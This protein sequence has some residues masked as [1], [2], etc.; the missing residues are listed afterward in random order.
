MNAKKQESGNIEEAFNNIILSNFGNR[1]GL[2]N[3]KSPVNKNPLR[4]T[5]YNSFNRSPQ[6]SQYIQDEYSQNNPKI[7]YITKYDTED[8]NLEENININ[9]YL[10]KNKKRI[11][12]RSPINYN[13]NQIQQ[14]NNYY[15]YNR[16]NNNINKNRV[17]KHFE[18]DDF[19]NNNMNYQYSEDN[20]NDNWKKKI[21]KI[22]EQKSNHEY[23]DKINLS[24][25]NNK[26]INY[27]N[28][29]YYQNDYDNH[30][31]SQSVTIN[32]PQ[33]KNFPNYSGKNNYNNFNKNY[34]NL[35]ND[36]YK[37]KASEDYNISYMDLSDNSFKNQT[38]Q[39]K[40]YYTNYNNFPNFNLNNDSST[41]NFYD[42][43]YELNK[44]EN[45]K[46]KLKNKFSDLSKFFSISSQENT[47]FEY[48]KDDDSYNTVA[49]RRPMKNDEEHY[50]QNLT[51]KIKKKDDKKKKREKAKASAR[52]P[53][54]PKYLDTTPEGCNISSL[55]DI[56]NIKEKKISNFKANP[57]EKKTNKNLSINS[58]LNYSNYSENYNNLSSTTMFIPPKKIKNFFSF[59]NPNIKNDY[60]A[61]V[62]NKQIKN[63]LN[64]NNNNIYFPEKDIS[65]QSKQLK[66]RSPQ[67]YNSFNNINSSKFPLKNRLNNNQKNIENI[68]I[69]TQDDLYNKKKKVNFDNK[70]KEITVDLS[71]RKKIFDLSSSNGN[72]NNKINNITPN[73][74]NDINPNYNEKFNFN[75]N[76]KPKPKTKIESCIITFDKPKRNVNNSYDKQ[77]KLSNSFDNLKF[78]QVKYV[79][80]KI[81]LNNN[82]NNLNNNNLYEKQG[83]NNIN[84]TNKNKNN[85]IYNKN[86]SAK[87]IYQKPGNRK[88][89]S[90]YGN[91]SPK[92]NDKNNEVIDYCA[93]SPDYGKRDKNLNDNIYSDIYNHSPL[94]VSGTFKVVDNIKKEQI[95]PYIQKYDEF[96]FKEKI[97]S[98]NNNTNEINY[99]NS[100][101]IKVK[102]INNIDNNN[103]NS[104]NNNKNNTK[105]KT[106]YMKKTKTTNNI[107]NN[108][109]IY[110]S[111]RIPT[112]SNIEEIVKDNNKNDYNNIN[113]SR[114]I[115]DKKINEVTPMGA[116][117][118]IKNIK[119][120][121]ITK[122]IIK[123]FS[124]K[125]KEIKEKPKV[126]YSFY[127]KYYNLY[128][129]L[130]QNELMY[131]S[132]T[133]YGIKPIKKPLLSINFISK[134]RYKYIFKLPISSRDYYTKRKIPNSL[135][136]PK[137]DV[138]YMTKIFFKNKEYIENKLNNLMNDKQIN[139][140][141]LQANKNANISIKNKQIK[142][143]IILIRKNNKFNKK[144]PNN[145]NNDNI[146]EMKDIKNENNGNIN[147]VNQK[148]N[149]SEEINNQEKINNYAGNNN[150]IIDD[151]LLNNLNIDNVNSE[152]NI[153]VNLIKNSRVN[154][155]INSM[156]DKVYFKKKKINIIKR[157]QLLP[158]KKRF[159]NENSFTS[160]NENISFN[161][162]INKETGG[163]DSKNTKIFF[164]QKSIDNSTIKSQS[165]NTSINDGL[166]QSSSY[167]HLIK[168]SALN[169]SV[170]HNNLNYSINNDENSLSM[171]SNNTI[172]FD[173]DKKNLHNKKN[174]FKIRT[175]IRGIKKQSKYDYLKN[176]KHNNHLKISDIM[177]GSEK[178]KKE[179]DKE[180]KI[181]II[182]K[183]DLDNYI[184]FYKISE[185]NKKQKYNWSMI[186]NL[187]IKIKS[188]I[189]DIINGYLQASEELINKKKDIIIANQY[190]K[191]IIH[192][193]K[194]N[195]L[196]SKNFDSIHNKLL[197][198]YLSIKEIKIYNSMKF[199]IL[200]KLLMNLIDNKLF[201]INDFYVFRQAD[202]KTK[203]NFKKILIYCDNGKNNLS[204]IHI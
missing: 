173:L 34:I 53:K 112:F 137:I 141:I 56:N 182:I 68:Q 74:L 90:S 152:R 177:R 92:E 15:N 125:K 202:E 43:S 105:I 98:N 85:F 157:E 4:S 186:E 83:V 175:I 12:N 170:I 195:Y 110:I 61:N 47:S 147:N 42:D 190:I 189:V 23:Y 185:K 93:P 1:R 44:T 155:E 129:K 13:Y 139:N 86:R 183:E 130:P 198:L 5:N 67:N 123:T 2:Q 172:N 52:Q 6:S 128:M 94:L 45:Y 79:R 60:R 80:K 24:N 54:E 26:K 124:N 134:D 64:N 106:I 193:Y 3:R 39:N 59:N 10:N 88:L 62:N 41:S 20:I 17:L 78:N 30:L 21:L 114:N 144:M 109:N 151:T 160:D 150:K 101:P 180:R 71:P 22:N 40:N 28:D 38:F 107:H 100:K 46:Q 25:N 29:N 127:K 84:E 77:F 178:T 35:S 132:K 166:N 31:L 76:I 196:T 89:S 65:I 176:Y 174:Q 204:R 135:I 136:L 7:K 169:F 91:N 116:N 164:S 63:N 58:D 145:L 32:F 57:K 162:N 167:A 192:H 203:S 87:K 197:Q 113:N 168:A 48:N 121:K 51:I 158:D 49:F 9:D 165:N 81:P 181:G 19:D 33:P 159:D 97:I 120:K 96:S 16:N 18:S 14:G 115:N 131:I 50:H 72:L 36:D 27:L 179:M 146:N 201:F 184:S 148:I 102:I 188:D 133:K 111:Q 122:L 138:A 171:I 118:E 11:V 142:K 70:I 69:K 163:G 143:R 95:S 199:E 154:N 140:N 149:I 37:K 108:N 161:L 103:V 200:G 8:I 153:N 73:Y 99:S 119:N 75:N 55:T 191:N 187:M 156:N 66:G 126:L 82:N 194:Y 104:F 117:D